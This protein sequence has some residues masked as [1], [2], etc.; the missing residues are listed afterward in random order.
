MATG[1]YWNDPTGPKPW[2]LFDTD[3]II[4]IP[5][6]IADWL[7]SLASTYQSHQILV[8]EPLEC[9]GSV[10]ASNIITAT[11]KVKAGATFTKGVKYP[12][13]VRLVCADGQ[14]DDRTLWLKLVDR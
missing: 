10:I 2:A 5:I 8:D 3:A 7:D 14:Q 11:M 6:E 9:T 13:T 12:F 1:S 4:E